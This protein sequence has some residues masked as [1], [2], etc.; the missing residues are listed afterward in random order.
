MLPTL[1]SSVYQSPTRVHHVMVIEFQC[2]EVVP[3]ISGDSSTLLDK[4]STLDVEILIMKNVLNHVE[5]NTL[6][7]YLM[8]WNG[9]SK[10]QKNKVYSGLCQQFLS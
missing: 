3:R 8:H 2:T 6:D 10:Q 1:D 4:T 9:F 7:Y 5:S